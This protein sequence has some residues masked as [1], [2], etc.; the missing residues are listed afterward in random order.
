MRWRR[1]RR[2]M[3]RTGARPSSRLRTSLRWAEMRAAWIAAVA[4]AAVALAAAGSALAG[5]RGAVQFQPVKI[6]VVDE[7]AVYK[8]IG[9]GPFKNKNPDGVAKGSEGT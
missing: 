6:E 4:V 1:P 5:E 3:G 8:P 9:D 2:W 7:K